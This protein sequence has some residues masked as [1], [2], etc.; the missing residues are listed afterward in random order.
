M[1]INQKRY[2]YRTIFLKK[3]IKLPCRWV[4][5][6][7]Y[8][9]KK[10]IGRLYQS[11]FPLGEEIKKN[12]IR[13]KE[14]NLAPLGGCVAPGSP[15]LPSPCAPPSPLPADAPAASA[16]DPSLVSALPKSS[17]DEFFGN[18]FERE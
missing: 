13:D 11:S 4:R 1:F 17:L 8:R 16:P 18:N 2:K 10:K 9:E 7:S 5:G 12:F 14:E 6:P 15:D 3:K